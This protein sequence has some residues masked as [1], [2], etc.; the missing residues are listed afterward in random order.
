[1][2]FKKIALIGVKDE[3]IMTRKIAVLRGINVGG[4]RKILM[5]D[6]KSTCEDLGWSNVKTYI[7]SGNLIFDSDST[8]IDLETQLE[9]AIKTTFN[10]SVPVIVRSKNELLHS[11]NSNPF[12]NK[13]SE[14]KHLYLTFL[15]TNTKQEYLK[16]IVDYNFPPDQFSINGK[17]VYV[18]CSESYHRSKLSN[19]FFEKNLHVTT[20]TRNWKT[21]LKLLDFCE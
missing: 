18:Y 5:A 13:D 16:Q 3:L 2:K 10:H 21:V 9:T 14:I 4:K 11:I 15:K 6:L 8:N 20:T 12:Y 19:T 1:M 7:Q 17:E